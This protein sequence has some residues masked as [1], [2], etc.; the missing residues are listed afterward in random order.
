MSIALYTFDKG[1]KDIKNR[2]FS[3][4]KNIFFEEISLN[5]LNV[6]F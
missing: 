3:V 6:D 2:F 1:K 4:E 5:S